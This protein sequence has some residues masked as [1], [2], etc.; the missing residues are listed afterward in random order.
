MDNNT[1]MVVSQKL[2]DILSPLILGD[3]ATTPTVGS[4]LPVLPRGKT[5]KSDGEGNT[6][7]VDDHDYMTGDGMFRKPRG[8]QMTSQKKVKRK[9]TKKT[10]RIICDWKPVN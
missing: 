3:T 4:L 10:Y 8:K 7:V 1:R 6:V 9:K 5:Y 2:H